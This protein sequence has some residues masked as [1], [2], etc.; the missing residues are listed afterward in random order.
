MSNEPRLVSTADLAERN[1]EERAAGYPSRSE[2]DR[3]ERGDASGGND[4]PQG[5]PREAIDDAAQTALPDPAKAPL[6]LST[7]DLAARTAGQP[8]NGQADVGQPPSNRDGQGRPPAA[9][10]PP[11]AP[12]DRAPLLPAADAQRLRSRWDDTQ[13]GFVDEPQASVEEADNLVAEL[14]QTLADSFATER[15]SLE[16]QWEHGEHGDTEQLRL[17]LRRYRSFFERLLSV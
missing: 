12:G 5:R 7:A 4:N 3:R 9:S 6:P 11:E 10:T 15:A 1:E 14:M 16:R 8:E 17:A 2:D 13:S